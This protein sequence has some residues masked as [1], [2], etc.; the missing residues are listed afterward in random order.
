MHPNGG[1]LY[2]ACRATSNLGSS[3][4]VLRITAAG[5]QG[6]GLLVA[7]FPT[8]GFEPRNLSVSPDGT[9][10]HSTW[11]RLPSPIAT[12]M[13]HDTVTHA[14]VSSGYTGEGLPSNIAAIGSITS[15]TASRVFVQMATYISP[16]YITHL[17]CSTRIPVRRSASRR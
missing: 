14:L 2:L 6:D 15:Q 5:L 8:S 12:L 10:L 16:N 11:S 4:I 9:R 1:A 13:V 7:S 17:Y 3:A